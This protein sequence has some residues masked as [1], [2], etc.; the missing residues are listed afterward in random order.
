MRSEVDIPD[1][2]PSHTVTKLSR[3]YIGPAQRGELPHHAAQENE[4]H[5]PF[6]HGHPLLLF[7]CLHGFGVATAAAL[8]AE[9]RERL[10]DTKGGKVQ[11]GRAD[12]LLGVRQ[13]VQD[14]RLPVTAHHLGLE[15]GLL[16]PELLERREI[17]C[18]GVGLDSR[19]ICCVCCGC[20]WQIEGRR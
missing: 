10:D 17:L 9:R 4:G 12:H 13:V 5:A 3:V 14:L 1:P 20:W 11:L 19:N 18:R 6:E 15:S 7:G 8:P 2:L 16:R